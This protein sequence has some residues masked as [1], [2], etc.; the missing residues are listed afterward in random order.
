MLSNLLSAGTI[1]IE[2][3]NPDIV[4]ALI[5]CVILIFILILG[6]E[7]AT[8]INHKKKLKKLDEV[9][10]KEKEESK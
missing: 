4:Y 6:M 8:R 5:F 9:I 2:D 1:V 10:Q 3:N 7:I